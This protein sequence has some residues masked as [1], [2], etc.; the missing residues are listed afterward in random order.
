MQLWSLMNEYENVLSYSQ[1]VCKSGDETESQSKKAYAMQFR[2]SN[3]R[4]GI[5]CSTV[6]VTRDKLKQ[7]GFERKRFRLLKSILHLVGKW[8][9]KLLSGSQ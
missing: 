8:K 6:V 7:S 9:D 1:L 4:K 5:F 3:H 2:L